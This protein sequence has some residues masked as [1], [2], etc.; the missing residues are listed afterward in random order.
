MRGFK[1]N[2]HLKWHEAL[3]VLIEAGLLVFGLWACIDSL[4]IGSPVAAYKFL[5]LF[6]IWALPGAMILA[7]FKPKKAPQQ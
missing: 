5:L 2:V 7:F 4:L 6:V 1:L 3:L